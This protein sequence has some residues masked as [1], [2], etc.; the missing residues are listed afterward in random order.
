MEMQNLENAIRSLVEATLFAQCT[1]KG[2]DEAPESEAHTVQC[3]LNIARE[4]CATDGH[5]L[6]GWAAA[7][8]SAHDADEETLASHLR[9]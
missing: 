7:L 3:A 6:G 5:P 8:L 9:P 4:I 2:V 1:I